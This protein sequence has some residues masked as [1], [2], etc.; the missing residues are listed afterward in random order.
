MPW[1]LDTALQV[2]ETRAMRPGHAKHSHTVCRLLVRACVR[3]VN[4]QLVSRIT[5]MQGLSCAVEP[6]MCCG[7]AMQENFT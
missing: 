3:M 7:K 5:Y 2:H 1:S 4:M 6:V